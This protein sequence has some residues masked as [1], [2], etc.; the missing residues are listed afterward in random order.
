MRLKMR[1]IRAFIS[2]LCALIFSACMGQSSIEEQA[3]MHSYELNQRQQAI[4]RQENLNENYNELNEFQ[5]RDIQ[6]IE[7]ALSYADE[8]YNM[9]FAYS[10]YVQGDYLEND[11]VLAYPA[12]GIKELDGFRIDIFRENNEVRYEDDFMNIAV[13]DVYAEYLLQALIPLSDADG[14]KIFADVTNTTLTQLPIQSSDIPGNV[15][16]STLIF[17][18]KEGMIQEEYNTLL[19]EYEQWLRQESLYGIFQVCLVKPG[20]L[21]KVTAFNYEQYLSDDSLLQRQTLNVQQD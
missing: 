5:Q 16:G 7:Q 15:G 11:Y 19:E 8:K 10:G 13:R 12:N 18:E 2:V 17:L 1:L 6:Q 4:L 20:V 14:I 9:I 3:T 21:Q